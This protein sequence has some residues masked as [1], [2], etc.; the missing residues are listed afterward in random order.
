VFWDEL[1]LLVDEFCDF[2]KVGS[3]FAV[4]EGLRRAAI[5]SSTHNGDFHTIEKP[6]EGDVLSSVRKKLQLHCCVMVVV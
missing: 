3:D 5:H 2:C 1:H 4:R 6:M